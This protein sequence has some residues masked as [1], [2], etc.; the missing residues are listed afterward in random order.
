M[1]VIWDGRCQNWD[2]SPHL[3]KQH[4]VVGYAAVVVCSPL[5]CQSGVKLTEPFF[6]FWEPFYFP[7]CA[8]LSVYFISY[9]CHM[10]LY[11]VPKM[12]PLQFVYCLNATT[13]RFW[14]VLK[15]L[16]CSIFCAL[17]KVN[18]KRLSSLKQMENCDWGAFWVTCLFHRF[19][20]AVK[21]TG[22]QNT[23][24]ASK[25]HC[26]FTTFFQWRAGMFNIVDSFA[27]L[28]LKSHFVFPFSGQKRQPWFNVF[29]SFLRVTGLHYVQ[30]VKFALLIL[31]FFLTKSEHVPGP[32]DPLS[33]I[34]DDPGGLTWLPWYVFPS[35]D[36]AAF[37]AERGG[38][39]SALYQLSERI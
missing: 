5:L 39:V 23:G 20:L 14:C 11:W 29:L 6:F 8:M 33:L 19:I 25:T 27:L 21:Q 1:G 35:S 16:P 30:L 2:K 22:F 32:R 9:K 13:M 7:Q 26:V 12:Q 10:H 36:Q 28:L 24:I 38:C 17:S 34:D 31:I 15:S 4:L 18:Q 3:V 37:L